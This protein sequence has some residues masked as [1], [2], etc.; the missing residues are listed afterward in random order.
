MEP[1]LCRENKFAQCF[2]WKVEELKG[3]KVAC[4]AASTLQRF[5]RSHPFLHPLGERALRAI[6]IVLN[7]KI[8]VDLEQTLL[9]RDGSEKLLPARI[10]S[11]KTCRTGFES[12]IG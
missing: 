8:L 4:I 3:L 12:S 10:I 5:N 7:T 9:V 11:E 2:R 1:T 6:G